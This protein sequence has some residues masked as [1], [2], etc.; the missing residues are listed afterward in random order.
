MRHYLLDGMELLYDAI[1]SCY[2][3]PVITLSD[4]MKRWNINILSC[5]VSEQSKMI[6]LTYVFYVFMELEHMNISKK[7]RL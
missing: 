4:A 6:G 2:L 3:K 7:Q 5:A 1:C